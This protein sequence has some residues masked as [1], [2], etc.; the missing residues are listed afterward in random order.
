[1]NKAIPIWK[2]RKKQFKSASSALLP[3]KHLINA[4]ERRETINGD[5]I[6]CRHNPRVWRL[7]RST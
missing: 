3:E 5:D 2:T 4:K 7:Y 1:M 6:I